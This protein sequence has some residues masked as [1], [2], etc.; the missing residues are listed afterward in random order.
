MER[1]ER[2]APRNALPERLVNIATLKREFDDGR[3]VQLDPKKFVEGAD[4]F[5]IRDIHVVHKVEGVEGFPF[6]RPV[7][8]EG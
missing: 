8:V 4:Q 1:A 6:A 7:F 2:F 3:Q 5:E